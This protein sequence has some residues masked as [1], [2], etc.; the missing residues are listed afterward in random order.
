MRL[1]GPV[2]D[3]EGPKCD[4]GSLSAPGRRDHAIITLIASRSFI[5]R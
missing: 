1:L 4:I 5:A 3:S 2:C